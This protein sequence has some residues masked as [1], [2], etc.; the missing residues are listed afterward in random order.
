MPPFVG[1]A[2]NVTLVPAQIVP[3]G[4][5]E[6]LTAGVTLAVTVTLIELA[7]VT[8]PVPLFL[9]TSVPLKV[10]VETTLGIPV[11]EIGVAGSAVNPTSA[12][13]AVLA[14]LSQS[15]MYSFGLPVVALY[16]NVLMV[17][18]EQTPGIP[19]RVI[20]GDAMLTLIGPKTAVHTVLASLIVTL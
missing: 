12:R 14:V 16:G 6:I 17:I 11:I 3:F 18:P 4:L 5:A 13:P 9:A 20:D 19:P 10:V 8:Q 1:E 15:I 2:V 7:A